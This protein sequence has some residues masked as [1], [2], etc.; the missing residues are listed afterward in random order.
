[1]IESPSQFQSKHHLP[2]FIPFESRFPCIERP[3]KLWV[4]DKTKCP[5]AAADAS[6]LGQTTFVGDRV[7]Q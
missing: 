5:V 3:R 7:S 4:T 2:A 6:T 1:M